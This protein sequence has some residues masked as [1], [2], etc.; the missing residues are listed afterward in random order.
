MNILLLSYIINAYCV[1]LKCYK[2]IYMSKII[3]WKMVDVTNIKW[4]TWK[5]YKRILH[6][7]LRFKAQVIFKW[8]NLE[9]NN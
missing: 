6:N 8:K 9:F 1:R 3:E 2:S 4:D 7:I 5:K